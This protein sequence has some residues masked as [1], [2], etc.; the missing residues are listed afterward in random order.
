MT[1]TAQ[2]AVTVSG[3]GKTV[4]RIRMLINGEWRAAER[5]QEIIDPYR[6]EVVALAPESSLQ[7]VNDA[8]AAASAAKARVATMPGYERAAL[9]RRVATLLAG[10]T[11][12]IAEV[13]ARE[14]GKAI[15]DA[16][17]EVARSP[18][19]ILLSAENAIRIEGEHVPLEGIA[20]G[21]ER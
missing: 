5:Y 1:G 7:D 11:D 3:S 18:D 20:M 13:M 10:R 19:T 2:Q 8:V 12:E 4:P 21:R 9:L 14:T 15:K 16:Y 6:G 17:A